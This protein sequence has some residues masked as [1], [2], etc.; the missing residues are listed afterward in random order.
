M[1]RKLREEREPV[2]RRQNRGGRPEIA[3]RGKGVRTRPAL[4]PRIAAS[5]EKRATIVATSCRAPGAVACRTRTRAARSWPSTPIQAAPAGRCASCAAI[6]RPRAVRLRR[7]VAREA[8]RGHRDASQHGGRPPGARGT[9]GSRRSPRASAT[10][11]AQGPDASTSASL[12]VTVVSAKPRDQ[13][14]RRRR[15]AR[16]CP[17]CRRPGSAAGG[18]RR[19]RRS[20]TPHPQRAAESANPRAAGQPIRIVA[21]GAQTR[22]DERKDDDQGGERHVHPRPARACGAARRPSAESSADAEA[23]RPARRVAV[24]SRTTRQRDDMGRARGGSAASRQV[25]SRGSRVGTSMLRA[26]ETTLRPGRP[27]QPAR[28]RGIAARAARWRRAPARRGAVWRLAPSGGD[29]RTSR[30]CAAPAAGKARRRPAAP[31]SPASRG[32]RRPARAPSPSSRSARELPCRRLGRATQVRI[33][34]RESSAYP[35]NPQ[36]RAPGDVGGTTGDPSSIGPLPRQELLPRVRR[37]LAGDPQARRLGAGQVRP[38]REA[39]RRARSRRRSPRRPAPPRRHRRSRPG[40]S[41]PPG[42]S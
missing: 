35:G 41:R 18:G 26:D 28:S 42:S 21:R 16:S 1:S 14:Q 4:P 32:A 36:L 19:G 38:R 3:P 40:S 20:A 10:A 13:R 24:P 37:Q 23:D 39:S 30:A 15:R 29:D 7:G 31:R 2:R 12:P 34:P 11:A 6:A 27:R 25:P 22:P 8:P 33:Y 17:R 9:Q 5:G